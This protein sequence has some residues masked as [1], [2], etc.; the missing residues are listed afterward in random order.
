MSLLIAFGLVGALFQSPAAAQNASVSG[1][2]VE[3][4]SR[5]PVAGAQVILFPMPSAPHAMRFH[6]PPTS[7][8]DQDGRYRFDALE[9]GRYG[10]SVRKAGFASQDVP[11]RP[12]VDLTPG[13][14]R[15]DVNLTVQ[16]GA[17][18]VG[19]V[20][21]EAGDPVLEAQ[22]MAFHKP[23]A[24]SSAASMGAHALIPGG[25]MVAT[26]NDLGEFRLFGLSPGE[27]YVQAMSRADFGE[28]HAPRA[29]RVLPTYFPGT[30]DALAAQPIAVA[31]GETSA[32]VVIRMIQVP[33]FQVSGVVLDQRGQPLADAVVRLVVDEPGGP[34]P[35][36]RGPL[37]Q[38]RSDA[39][40]KFTIGNVTSGTY[41]LVAIAPV[42]I[43]R[44]TDRGPASGGNNGGSFTTFGFGS[45]GVGGMIGGGVTT[46]T[47]NGTT[48]Q[49]RD[50]M[51]TRVP[52]T[53]T[54]AN[55]SG[56]EVIVR[57]AAR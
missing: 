5:A 19:R 53:V 37:T 14:H 36:L 46:E 12:N 48:I 4:G 41:T 27:Y 50:D 42:V 49:Y 40:G 7:I 54:A 15:D 24:A 3:E 26:T 39:T 2:V 21:D 32:D 44:P 55:V 35:F 33:A 11:G 13:E 56:L 52:I 43:S 18:I 20:L 51:A 25:S 8:T 29:M 57:A 17:V 31:A 22:V 16:K 45:G 30:S 38:S 28:S 1:Q 47:R 23:P 6:Q 34:M 9:P 10:I